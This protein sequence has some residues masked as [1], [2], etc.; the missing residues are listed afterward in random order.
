MSTACVCAGRSDLGGGRVSEDP[1]LSLKSWF[2]VTF[3]TG[4]NA[5]ALSLTHLRVRNP[6]PCSTAFRGGLV[7]SEQ[8]RPC[9]PFGPRCWVAEEKNL[10]E[11]GLQCL[12]FCVFFFLPS[13]GQCQ[14]MGNSEKRGIVAKRLYTSSGNLSQ[15]C[16]RTE[17]RARSSTVP[18]RQSAR[19]CLPWLCSSSW[20]TRRRGGTSP[21]ANKRVALHF[22]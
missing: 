1:E 3:D 21:A 19:G 12:S 11:N 15:P 20:K 14:Q 9:V 10:E 16:I 2:K 4:T 18:D 17:T 13:D 6:A 8:R 22:I 5:S 7:R